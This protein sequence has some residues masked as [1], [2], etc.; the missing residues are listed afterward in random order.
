MHTL[1]VSQFVTTCLMYHSMYLTWHMLFIPNYILCT[2][3]YVAVYIEHFYVL[4]WKM[5]CPLWTPAAD[6]LAGSQTFPLS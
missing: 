2:G 1:I 5:G 3:P 4:V 6:W